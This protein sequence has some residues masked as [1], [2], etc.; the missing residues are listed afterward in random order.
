MSIEEWD[1][2]ILVHL[3]G[4]FGPLRHA[5]AYWRDRAKAG[6]DVDAVIV[7]TSSG[8]GIYANPGQGNYGAAKAGIAAL[9]VIAAQD[10]ARYGVRVNA[11]AP[12]AHTRMTDDR[13]MGDF[14]RRLAAEDP[15]A[16]N[17]Y[18]L[19][20]VAPWLSGWSATPRPRSPA[21]SST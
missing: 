14:V 10:L 11:I 2:V 20:N 8:S 19:D 7:N 13:P 6:K 4:T 17:A 15:D 21:E 18:H 9:T 3:R 16:F 12:G 5:A 1:A